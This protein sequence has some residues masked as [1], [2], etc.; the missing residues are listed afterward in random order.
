MPKEKLDFVLSVIFASF[1]ILLLMVAAFMLFR[2]YIKRKNKLLL[3]KERMSIQYEQ[4]LLQSKLE[5][6]EQT[7]QY[8]SQELHDNI[9]QVLSLVSLNLNTMN[10]PGEITRITHMDELLGRALTDLRNLSH[11]LDADHIRDNG[12][13]TPVRKLLQQ[14][15]DTGKY[16]TEVKLE[17]DL[18]A[19][20]EERPIILFRMIQEVISNINKHASADTIIFIAQ[21]KNDRLEIT[22]QDNGKGFDS[23][24]ASEGA[25]LR[26]L[27]NRAKLID[28]NLS[29]DSK[30]GK[31]TVV[32][33][34]IK[35]ENIE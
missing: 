15:Q 23:R 3:E 25:G 18:P 10:A 33:I 27:Q 26:N 5:I 29:F 19:L 22:I 17:D 13:H 21:K 31:G 20:A 7:F 16:T 8:I 2:I 14:L 6:Q 34:S 32:T 28:A 24:I 35:T 12:W 30:P 4:T 11:S 9:G 1:F